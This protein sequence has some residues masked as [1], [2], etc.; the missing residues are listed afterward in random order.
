VPI[1]GG[2]RVLVSATPGQ[3]SE[4][5]DVMRQETLERFA[6]SGR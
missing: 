6:Q 5:L 3:P 2:L 1:D 4:V